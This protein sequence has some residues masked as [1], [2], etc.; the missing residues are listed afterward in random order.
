MKNFT[1]EFL[2]NYCVRRNSMLLLNI[3]REMRLAQYRDVWRPRAEEDR[4]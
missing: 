1:E 4:G 2:W 3:R